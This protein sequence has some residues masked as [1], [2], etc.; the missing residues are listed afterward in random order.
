MAE[1]KQS[2]IT[3]KA[4]ESLLAALRGV[5]NRSAF[6]RSAVLAALENT[7]PLC[8]GTGMLTPR[9]K[10]HWDTFARDH[11]IEECIDRLVNFSYPVRHLLG[12]AVAWSD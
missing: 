12:Q 5:P 2:I 1:Q 9:Q 11:A 7:C 4:E 10:E 3:F 8:R 6:I